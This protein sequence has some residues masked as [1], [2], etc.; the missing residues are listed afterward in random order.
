MTL[1]NYIETVRAFRNTIEEKLNHAFTE[2]D[3]GNEA[4]MEALYNEPFT[5][6]FNGMSCK[7]FFGAIEYNEITN[8]L[9][10]ILEDL[11]E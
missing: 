6:S 7:L 1:E 10:N 9:D 2:M 3:N 11:S 5:I 4:P 8:A